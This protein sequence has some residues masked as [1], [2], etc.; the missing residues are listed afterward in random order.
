MRS[1]PVSAWKILGTQL[2]SVVVFLLAAAGGISL[3]LAD[4][5]EA[6]AIGTVLGL[7]T[8]IGFIT[9]LRA[10][11]AMEALLHFDVPRAV[12]LRSGYIR[13]VEA[14][15]SRPATS[16]VERRMLPRRR[17]ARERHGPE[18]HRGR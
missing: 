9:E 5:I 15:A 3:F 17:P 6:A 10:R 7:N 13:L 14:T 8:A 11:R 16:S 2:T 4:Y 1:P 12:V 18:G